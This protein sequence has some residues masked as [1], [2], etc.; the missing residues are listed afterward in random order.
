MFIV[1][2]ST[3]SLIVGH[4]YLLFDCFKHCNQSFFFFQKIFIWLH[5]VSADPSMPDILLQHMDSLVAV[6]GLSG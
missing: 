5:W 2:N 4:L 3:C 6:L 1:F